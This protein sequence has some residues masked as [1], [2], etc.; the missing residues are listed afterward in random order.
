M[1]FVLLIWFPAPLDQLTGYGLIF[2][3]ASGGTGRIRTHARLSPPI[4]FQDCSLMT[5]WVLFQMFAPCRKGACTALPVFPGR[6]RKENE[7][8]RLWSPMEPV[9]GIEPALPAWKAG[10]LPLSYTDVCARGAVL[11]EPQVFPSFRAV[12]NRKRRI[13]RRA[14]YARVEPLVG[15]EPTAC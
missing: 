15:F 8:G 2:T 11:T 3:Q 10:A 5:T 13:L 4:S 6:H 12:R 9:T 1:A 7:D 14:V